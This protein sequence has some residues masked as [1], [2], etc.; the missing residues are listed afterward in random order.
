MIGR[1]AKQLVA[2]GAL[3]AALATPPLSAQK[4]AKG[5]AP[6]QF[7]TVEQP[8]AER[9]KNEFQELLRRY[10]PTLHNVFRQDPTLLSNESYLAPYPALITFL[11]S[12][13]EITHNPTFYT[14][15]PDQPE[16]HQSR[17]LEM[18]QRA[19]GDF[20]GV[21]AFSIGAT[22][23]LVIGR[24]VID[25]RRWNRLSKTQQEVHT[26]ILD[27]FSNNDELMAYVTSQAGS[28]FLQ[29]APIS[30]ETGTPASRNMGA[31]LSRIMWSVQVGFVLAAAGGGLMI[32]S[33]RVTD[34]VSLP[35]EVMGIVAMALGIGFVVSAGVSYLMSY[36]LGLLEAPPA[37]RTN[38]SAE[39]QQ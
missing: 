25:Y 22:L 4:Q 35:L 38:D 1:K 18:W 15:R 24:A 28:R 36:R 8:D 20:M 16:D 31:P 32:A 27:R 21:L 5:D 6:T 3:A 30:L 9:T 34:D 33:S 2:A 19:M 11:N 29:S 12:H 7:V 10:P 17:T 13:P 26:K 14:G 37:K 23:F 39:L